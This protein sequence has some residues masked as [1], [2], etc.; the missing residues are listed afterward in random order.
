MS[1]VVIAGLAGG[2][3]GAAAHLAISWA[4]VMMGW[5]RVIIVRVAAAVVL[6]NVPALGPLVLLTGLLS[7]FVSGALFGVVLAWLLERTGPDLALVKGATF[8]AVLWLVPYSLLTPL[9]VPDQVV[10]PDALSSLLLL[11]SHVAYGLV[12]AQTMVRFARVRS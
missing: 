12:A 8:G 3:A 9:F 6:R 1:D 11:A 10:R 5:S 4:A 7:H 2:T